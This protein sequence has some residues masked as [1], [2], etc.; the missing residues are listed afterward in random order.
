MKIAIISDTHFGD[1]ESQLVTADASGQCRLGKRYPKFRDA[2]GRDND[3][4]V[5]LGDIA[6][7]AIKDYK[8]ALDIFKLFLNQVFEDGIAKR[9]LY[10]PGNH[11]YDVWH[12]IEY[13]ANIIN[14]II[15]RPGKPTSL[16]RM[17][18]PAILDDRPSAKYKFFLGNV[19]RRPD[20]KEPYGHMF[21]DFLCDE[22]MRFSVGFPNAYL[23]TNEGECIMMTHGQYF[24]V[25]W[26]LVSDWAPKVFQADLKVNQPLLSTKNLV[27]LNFPL[28]QLSSSGV[29]QAGP[30]TDVIR[31][32]QYDFKSS[33]PERIE[34]Y[35]DNLKKEICSSV[36]KTKWYNPFDWLKKGV[37][38]IVK[39]AIMKG[40]MAP[41]PSPKDDETWDKKPETLEKMSAYYLSGCEEIKWLNSEYE[42]NIPLRPTKLIYGHT[43]KPIPLQCEKPPY[44][45]PFSGD[46]FQVP[47]FNAGCWLEDRGAELFLYETGK[48]LMSVSIT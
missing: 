42:M 17:S 21:L 33:K 38:G 8:T 43:H 46:P 6:D 27:E 26:A 34:V 37:L 48:G 16:F 47:T 11:D 13:Q 25:F 28:S 15:H 14:P 9:I 19:T 22:K 24:Q 40:I 32:I 31:Q 12:T 23:V 41:H 29:G 45:K 44:L 20:P 3:Y 10:I 7:V 18:V 36:L 1:F 2:A 30:L 4:L 5:L 35:L 39:K